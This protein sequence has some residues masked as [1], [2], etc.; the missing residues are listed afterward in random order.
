MLYLQAKKDM[1][2]YD[3]WNKSIKSGDIFGVS[4]STYFVLHTRSDLVVPISS[5][6]KSWV[7]DFILVATKGWKHPINWKI[8]EIKEWD[9]ITVKQYFVRQ[10]LLLWF[11]WY[12]GEETQETQEI[13]EIQ[14]TQEIQ[15]KR[16]RPPKV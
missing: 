14:E 3:W 10:F 4:M 9:I 6:F 7:W 15:R 11:V 13:Q 5:E 2:V 12:S 1:V 16:W 8:T